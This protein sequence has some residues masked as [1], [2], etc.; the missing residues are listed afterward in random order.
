MYRYLGQYD[1]LNYNQIGY[2]WQC[3]KVEEKEKSQIVE[4][5]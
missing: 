2:K 1:P 5:R 3:S 4:V